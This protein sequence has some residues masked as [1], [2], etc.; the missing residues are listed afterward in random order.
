MAPVKIG[1]TLFAVGCGIFRTTDRES[2]GTKGF[3]VDSTGREES[4]NMPMLDFLA[5]KNSLNIVGTLQN[6]SG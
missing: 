5:G 6:G 4:A 2:T 3:I 1:P